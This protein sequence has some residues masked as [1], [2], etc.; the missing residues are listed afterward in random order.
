MHFLQ[1]HEEAE[2]GGAGRGGSGVR[3]GWGGGAIGLLSPAPDL[4]CRAPGE[5]HVVPT[6]W[7]SRPGRLFSATG[8]CACGFRGGAPAVG[9]QVCVRAGQG[10]AV[11]WPAS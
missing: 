7:W 9:G 11:G 10:G 2:R 8:T 5:P 4:I 1:G 6:D 3:V